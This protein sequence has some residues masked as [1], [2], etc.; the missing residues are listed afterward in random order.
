MNDTDLQKVQTLFAAEP[1]PPPRVIAAGRAR[2]ERSYQRRSF[3]MPRSS[4]P[5][6]AT[7]ATATMAAA[8]AVAV[9]LSSS[10]SQAPNGGTRIQLTAATMTLR[11]AAKVVA[12]LSATRPAPQQ[13]LLITSVE[14]D[15]GGPAVTSR[16]WMTFNGQRTSYYQA[17]KLVTHSVPSATV[18]DGSPMAAYDELSKLPPYPQALLAA[19]RTMSAGQVAVTGSAQVREWENIVQLLWNSPV[20]APPKLQAEIFT[21][22]TRLPGMR[23]E[24]LK[25]ALGKPAIGLYL[26]AAGHNDLLL[27]PGTYQVIG[28]LNVASGRYS[29][30]VTKTFKAK[31]VALPRGGTITW[32]IVRHTAFVSGPGQN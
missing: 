29:R 10:P 22:L 1:P 14:H 21:A 11:T 5:I 13:W 8:V 15:A 16:E 28:R 2:L 9:S 7:L 27:E 30:A 18:V 32:S 20:A 23:V 24:H 31:G 17:G 25:D 3:R 12:R 6:L 4:M 26:P 19:L